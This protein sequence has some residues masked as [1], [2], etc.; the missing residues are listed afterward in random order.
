MTIDEYY[1]FLQL[2]LTASLKEIKKRHRELA[3]ELHPDRKRGA[4]AEAKLK[5]AN[6]VYNRLMRRSADEHEQAMKVAQ[7]AQEAR[8]KREERAPSAEQARAYGDGL[9]YQAGGSRT[10]SAGGARGTTSSS[11]STTKPRGPTG[12][13]SP[14]RPPGFFEMQPRPPAPEPELRQ[15]SNSPLLPILG[16]IFQLIAGGLGLLVGGF[17]ML[18]AWVIGI[19]LVLAAVGG[20]FYLFLEFLGYLGGHQ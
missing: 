11:S 5:E 1:R 9:K 20:A 14:P 8:A 12:P 2:P 19:L 7:A 15:E 3:K 13:P 17:L 6:E 4:D 10:N 18:W 16:G